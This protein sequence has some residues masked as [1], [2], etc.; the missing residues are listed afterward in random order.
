[1]KTS[2]SLVA[3]LTLTASGFVT[4]TTDLQGDL[5][6]GSGVYASFRQAK[7]SAPNPS[8]WNIDGTYASVFKFK[9]DAA[10][11]DEVKIANSKSLSPHLSSVEFKDILEDGKACQTADK[12]GSLVSYT[13]DYV[14]TVVGM[15]ESEE[16]HK[17]SSR[18]STNPNAQ[19]QL[20]GTK[21]LQHS[22]VS[23]DHYEASGPNIFNARL[24]GE[25]LYASSSFYFNVKEGQGNSVVIGEQTFSSYVFVRGVRV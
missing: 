1:M 10:C 24:C 19:A 13:M 18:L 8:N 5:F 4:P 3:A 20:E 23:F 22:R 12:P 14:K 11:P 6:L 17:F 7:Q 9:G 2:L 16:K 25:R 15:E 21:K